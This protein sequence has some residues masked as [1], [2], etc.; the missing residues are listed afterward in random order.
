MVLMHWQCTALCCLTIDDERVG[1][2][3]VN[4]ARDGVSDFARVLLQGIG[5]VDSK[6]VQVARGRNHMEL[7]ICKGE[8]GLVGLT[9]SCVVELTEKLHLNSK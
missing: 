8:S 3:L 7:A 4:L 6:D 5:K 9:H 2:A 1:L